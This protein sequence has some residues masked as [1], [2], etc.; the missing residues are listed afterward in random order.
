MSVKLQLTPAVA[1]PRRG[2]RARRPT[3]RYENGASEGDASDFEED[4][5][6]PD[7]PEEHEWCPKRKLDDQVVGKKR[8]HGGKKSEGRARRSR[9]VGVSWN[10]RDQKWQAGIK[11]RGVQQNLGYFDDEAE[12]ARAFDAAVVK[13][14]LHRPLNFADDTGAEQAHKQPGLY[15]R[16]ELGWHSDPEVV[17][18]LVE[19]NWPV[20]PENVAMVQVAILAKHRLETGKPKSDIM[21]MLRARGALPPLPPPAARKKYHRIKLGWHDDPAV[22]ETLLEMN[23]PAT[24]ENVAQVQLAILAKHRLET[25]KP[26]SQIMRMLRA[27]GALPPKP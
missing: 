7:D 25:G 13:Q 2:D 10:K 26:K 11:V 19:V 23:W 9:Y 20:T 3:A 21:R 27:R 18:T 1:L 22:L 14:N 6:S 8:K 15:D 16:L 24:P 17:E 12:G 5:S 4:A